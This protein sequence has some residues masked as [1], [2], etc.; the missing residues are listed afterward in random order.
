M[1]TSYGEDEL[2]EAEEKLVVGHGMA[3]VRPSSMNRYSGSACC[4]L[5]T[6]EWRGKTSEKRKRKTRAESCSKEVKWPS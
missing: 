6:G 3:K 1:K 4:I 5:A 2:D